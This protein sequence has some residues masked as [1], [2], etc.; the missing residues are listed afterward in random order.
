MVYLD[1]QIENNNYF[2]GERKMLD[3][4]AG[5]LNFGNSFYEF[6]K[7]IGWVFVANVLFL[8]TSI[9][10]FTIGASLTAM[11][12]VMFKLVQEREFKLV[13]EYFSS[14]KRNFSTS[15]IIW[16][17][18]LV[19][20]V[21]CYVDISFFIGT[22]SSFGSMGY[23]MLAIAIVVT[24]AFLMFAL[25]VFPIIAEFESNMGDTFTLLKFVAKKNLKKCIWA[26][27]AT[28]LIFGFAILIIIYKLFIFIY[29]PFV[30]VGLNA[31]VLAYIYDSVLRPYYE[32]DEELEEYNGSEE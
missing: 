26:V 8:V 29:Y 17:I 18:C 30:A 12:S 21:I 2:K 31:L 24:L 27:I 22:I 3:K 20:G 16:L 32:E 11:Y 23:L 6:M 1:K 7:K 19:I 10:I 14:F 13:K 28:V 25:A 15:T 4:V 9:P 5:I